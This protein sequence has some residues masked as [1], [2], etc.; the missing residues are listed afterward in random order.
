MCTGEW[1]ADEGHLASGVTT[2]LPSAGGAAS[3][4]MPGRFIHILGEG[5]EGG[6]GGGGVAVASPPLRCGEHFSFDGGRFSSSGQAAELGFDASNAKYEDFDFPQSI[7]DNPGLIVGESPKP[8]R[9]LK[10]G[11][12]GSFLA[13]DFIQLY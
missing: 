12:K 1:L 11:A 8:P 13:E 10:F 7:N 2:D 3:V 6:G 4:R 9:V 5:S